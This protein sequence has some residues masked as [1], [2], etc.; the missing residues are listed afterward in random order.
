MITG[1]TFIYQPALYDLVVRVSEL[2][3]PLLPLKSSVASATA[4]SAAPSIAVLVSQASVAW[5]MD[6]TTTLYFELRELEAAGDPTAGEVTLSGLKFS[7]AT[8]EEQLTWL[9]LDKIIVHKKAADTRLQVD[10][11]VK[12]VWKPNLHVA[13]H[14]LW[15]NVCK[16]QTFFASVKTSAGPDVAGPKKGMVLSLSVS[17][18][19]SVLVHIGDHTVKVRVPKLSAK[20]VAAGISWVQA[21]DLAVNMNNKRVLVMDN[22]LLSAVE[23]SD[24]LTTE[25]RRM[26]GVTL[27]QNKCFVV[28]ANLFAFT[29]PYEFDFHSI[30]FEEMLGVVKWLKKRHFPVRDDNKT[31][32]RDILI[33]IKHF[34]IEL[35]D[36]PF[37]V[38]LRDNYEL[39]KDEYLE[40]QTRLKVLEE[41]IAEFRRKN[42]MFPSEKVE[43]ALQNLKKKNAEIYIQRA[44]RNYANCEPRTRLL[45]WEMRGLEL[46]VLADPSMHGKNEAIR[47]LK[48]FDCFSPWPP[49]CLLEF[50]TLWCRWVK[51]ESETF[52]IRETINCISS[53]ILGSWCSRMNK[54]KKFLIHMSR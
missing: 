22:I 14:L 31:L 49:D 7:L 36:D 19:L 24:K 41:R 43:E 1:T 25:R 48:E 21:P 34:K 33:N 20:Y 9:L 23:T 15:E 35:S 2:V 51:F 42:L 30:F 13:L 27:R 16:L 40:S 10:Q 50:T 4:K 5:S 38:R 54:F 39:K 12:L 26:E 28:A 11:R 47:H 3:R 53:A 37:E 52:T 6:A 17:D 8:G 45:E 18:K 44:H 29:E 46:M 32:P